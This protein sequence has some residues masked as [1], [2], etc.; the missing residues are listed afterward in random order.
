M[1]TTTAKECIPQDPTN[2]HSGEQDIYVQLVLSTV[3]GV[4]AFLGFCFLRPRWKSLYAAR[5]RQSDAATVLP[6]L[7]D[8]WFGWIPV[9]YRVSEQEV[10]ASAGLDA[11]AVSLRASR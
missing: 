5:K 2:P 8:T 10:L 9:L 6:E 4:S 7:P 3:L 11:F 1:D